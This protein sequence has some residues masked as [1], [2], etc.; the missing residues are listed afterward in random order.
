MRASMAARSMLTSRLAQ[1]GSSSR[2]S[3]ATSPVNCSGGID[4]LLV[5]SGAAETTPVSWTTATCV[6][7][8]LA[9]G[10]AGQLENH[11]GEIGR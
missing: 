8:A 5:F 11:L 3:R 6:I 9:K 1:T 10:V 4:R 7:G 2:A